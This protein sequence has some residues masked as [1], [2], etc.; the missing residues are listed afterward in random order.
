MPQGHKFSYT[1][2]QNRHTGH[3][4][5]SYR[6]NGRSTKTAE[7]LGWATVNRLAGGGKKSGSGRVGN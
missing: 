4:E 6:K 3:I 1:N 5:A 2:K 7:A